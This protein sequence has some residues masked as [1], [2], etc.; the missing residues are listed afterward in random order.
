MIFELAPLPYPF[1]GLEPYISQKTLEYHYGKHHRAYINKLN[2]LIV[3]SDFKHASSLKEIILNADAGIFNN[4]AQAWNHDFYWKSMTTP[5]NEEVSVS[6]AL[7][8]AIDTSFGSVNQFK[9]QFTQAAL[10]QFGSGWVWLVQEKNGSL[11]IMKT[12][13]AGNPMTGG[14]EPLLTCDVWE[15]A[16]Y[17]DTRNDRAKY[18]SHFWNVVNWNFAAG[19]LASI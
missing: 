14:Y 6:G 1:N 4:A 8:E 10:S 7:V 5:L 12:S 17:I 18:V 15:H 11:A 2:D 16:Y 13:N 3:N 9:E 19:N